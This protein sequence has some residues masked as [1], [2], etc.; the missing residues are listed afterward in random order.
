MTIVPNP[1]APP[2]AAPYKPNALG[3]SSLS[4]E[5][6]MI[7]SARGLTRAAIIPDRARTGISSAAPGATMARNEVT[8]TPISP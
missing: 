7:A 6:M 2:R 5:T 1:P 8:A 4:K 3:R